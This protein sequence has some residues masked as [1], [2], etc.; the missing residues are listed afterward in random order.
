MATH[1]IVSP[2]FDDAVLSCWHVLT[3][4]A[5]VRVVNVYAGTPPAGTPAGWWDQAL[6]DPAQAV[7][8]RAAEDSRAL[9]RAGRVARNLEFLDA[10][11]R[12]AEQPVE[13]IVDVLR[14]AIPA[15]AT[16]YAPACLGG[17]PDHEAVRDAALRLRSGGIEVRLYADLPHAS[18]KGWPSWVAA[19][20]AGV[21]RVWEGKLAAALDAG[22]LSEPTVTHLTAADV[23]AKLAAVREY[24][25]QAAPAELYFEVPLD[26]PEPLR[27]EVLWTL[28]PEPAGSSSARARARKPAAS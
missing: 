4:D 15:G 16:A 23:D 22:A 10:Q 7:A 1:V 2:H 21:D 20:G 25:S 3:A 8:A 28:S 26:D 19:G 27:Y 17:N 11:Y 12:L 24:A 6:G 18:R 9:A 13:P 5:D 14:D